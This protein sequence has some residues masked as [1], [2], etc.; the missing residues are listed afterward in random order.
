SGLPAFYKDDL[1]T[2]VRWLPKLESQLDHSEEQK[3]PN[4]MDSWYLYHPLMNLARLTQRGDKTA[5]KILMNSI[6]Y[7][8]KVART[9]DYNWPVFYQMETLKI[10]KEETAPGEGGELD[11]PG[12]YADLMLKM[13]SITKKKKYINEAKRSVK[14]L[15]G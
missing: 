13:W 15:E 14:K 7:A 2:I 6:D 5:K 10:I 3:K 8:I 1:K 11:V 12:S 4:V 9:F